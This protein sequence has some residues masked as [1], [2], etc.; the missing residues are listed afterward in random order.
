MI[1]SWQYNGMHATVTGNLDDGR[2]PLRVDGLSRILLVKKENVAALLSEDVP[3]NAATAS[4][5]NKLKKKQQRAHDIAALTH[6]PNQDNAVTNDT[7]TSFMPLNPSQ[8]YKVLSSHAKINSAPLHYSAAA[9]SPPSAR[10]ETPSTK[11]DVDKGNDDHTDKEKEEAAPEDDG[12][13][14]SNSEEGKEEEEEEEKKDHQ[15]NSRRKAGGIAY[16]S[17]SNSLKRVSEVKELAKMTVAQIK[18]WLQ[19]N[20]GVPS[21]Q[22]R[23]VKKKKEWVAMMRKRLKVQPSDHMD[24]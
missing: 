14:M 8:Q 3:L 23:S 15:D 18:T 7:N 1:K 17:T 9:V 2:F 19:N 24:T 12:Q 20:A 13:H 10:E 16:N 22:L 21:E 5:N 4:K 11:N 6:A